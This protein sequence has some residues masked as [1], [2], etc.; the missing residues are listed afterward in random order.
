MSRSLR[1]ASL[2]DLPPRLRDRLECACTPAA[3]RNRKQPRG[4]VEHE[5]QVV[6][7]NRIHALAANEPRF[8]AAARRTH[9]IPNGGG[10]SKAEAGRLKAEGVTKGVSDIF[11]AM[12]N[13]SFH[14]LYIEMKSATGRVSGEQAAWIEESRMLGY[15]GAV[16]RS[17]DEAFDLWRTYNAGCELRPSAAQAK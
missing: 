2:Q 10:R 8:A 9:A 13:G 4:H 6:F 15:A 1:Y 16:C 17:A 3:A 5:Q 14:G 12:P 7:F 11:C